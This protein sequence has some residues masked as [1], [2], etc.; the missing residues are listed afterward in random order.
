MM[1]AAEVVTKVDPLAGV[2]V[3]AL[4]FVAGWVVVAAVA[5]LAHRPTEPDAAPDTQELGPEPPAI[6]NLLTGTFEVSAEA[7]PATLVDLA[8]RRLVEL[9]TLPDGSTV[10]R[11]RTSTAD[12]DA[13]LAPYESQVLGLLRDKAVN[14]VVPAGALTTGTGERASAFWKSFRKA[15]I[16]DAQQRGLCRAVWGKR[17]SSLLG[18]A[19]LLPFLLIWAAG[20]FKAPDEVEWTPLGAVTIACALAI[21]FL[22]A[23]IAASDRQR[24]TDAGMQ[25]ASRWLGVRGYLSGTATFPDLPPAHVVLWDRYLAYATAFGVARACVRALP[26]SAEP[27]RRAWSSYGGRWR[28]VKVRYPK[29]RPGWGMSPWIALLRGL[30]FGAFAGF[31]TYVLLIRVDPRDSLDATGPASRYVAWAVLGAGLICLLVTVRLGSLVVQALNDLFVTRTVEGE[32]LRERTW[33]TDENIT[34]WVAVDNGK[35]PVVRAWRVSPARATEVDQNQVVRAR[36]TP[37][38]GFVRSFERLPVVSK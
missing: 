25:A 16:A 5:Y 18:I 4:A 34:H 38:L 19:A 10:C 36:V 17:I 20:R 14:G 37:L 27:D 6:A 2:L 12:R 28:Q 9:E 35:S 15:V 29:L 1:L 8:A 24:G 3:A 30:F 7:M 31:I 26:M 11:L 32:V 21:A 22:G 23:R 13:D 33:G